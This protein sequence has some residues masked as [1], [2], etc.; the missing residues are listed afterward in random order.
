M[1]TWKEAVCARADVLAPR[2]IA[3]S[4]EIY[5]HP[6]LKFE[7]RRASR[8]LAEELAQAGFSVELGVGGLETAIRAVHPAAQAGPRVAILAEYDALPEIGHACG[9]NLIATSACG[10]CLALGGFHVQS[11]STRTLFRA[12]NWFLFRLLFFALTG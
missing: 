4:Q 8:L 11:T 9:H 2:L 6:E 1:G 3:M 5:D 7:E 12:S 10:A